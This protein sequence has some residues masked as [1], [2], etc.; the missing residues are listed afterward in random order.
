MG[1]LIVR[2][3][4]FSP[5]CATLPDTLLVRSLIIR[6]LF[7][8]LGGTLKVIIFPPI[9]RKSAIGRTSTLCRGRGALRV[10]G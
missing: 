9:R 8:L 7:A 3:G 2:R 4:G 5:L 6:A 1:P 10:V